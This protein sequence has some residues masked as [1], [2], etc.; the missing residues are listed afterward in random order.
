MFLIEDCLEY[1]EGKSWFT[2]M[3]LKSGFYHVRLE[4]ES[5]KY[6]SFVVP[7]GQYEFLMGQRYFNDS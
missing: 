5:V 2:I 6:T 3:D 7:N 4:E 1:L